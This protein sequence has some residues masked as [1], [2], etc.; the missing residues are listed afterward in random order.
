[1][2]KRICLLAML[3]AVALLGACASAG[4]EKTFVTSFYPMYIFAQ[5]VAKDVPGV[6]IV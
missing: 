1:M 3:L 2:K 6:Q 4:S 5:N